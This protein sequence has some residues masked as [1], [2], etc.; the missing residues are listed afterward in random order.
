[1][2]GLIKFNAILMTLFVADIRTTLTIECLR[3]DT[4]RLY[5]I[6]VRT[7]VLIRLSV[8]LLL[9][10]GT[11]ILTYLMWHISINKITP[12]PLK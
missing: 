12:R 1:M 9:R 7:S 2:K 11:C 10:L 4:V 3:S 6:Q 8:E 5:Y